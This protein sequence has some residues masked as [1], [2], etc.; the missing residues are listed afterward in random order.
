MSAWN[1][2]CGRHGTPTL[3]IPQNRVFMV[4]RNIIMKGPC[5][6]KNI[7]IQVYSISNLPLIIQYV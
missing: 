2:I 1:D 7:N 4:K 5:K 3:L 6:A